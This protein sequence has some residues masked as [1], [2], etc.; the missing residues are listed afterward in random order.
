[1][2]A[3]G[4]FILSDPPETTS[5]HTK[6]CKVILDIRT[7][8]TV[9]ILI[10]KNSTVTHT[11]LSFVLQP[12]TWSQSVSALQSTVCFTWSF[13]QYINCTTS[14]LWL[15]SENFSPV[16]ITTEPLMSSPWVKPVWLAINKQTK[17]DVYQFNS[18]A[19]HTYT[20]IVFSGGFL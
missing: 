20:A 13:L 11:N 2:L 1:M 16:T 8:Y 7:M 3:F 6:S 12:W 17:S 9:K 10:I 19:S 5:P 18:I 15:C 4:G 14:I